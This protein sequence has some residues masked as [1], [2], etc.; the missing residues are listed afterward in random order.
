V[1]TV[2][3]GAGSGCEGRRVAGSSTVPRASEA[4]PWP[5]WGTAGRYLDGRRADGGD[6]AISLP[7]G[8]CTCELCSTLKAFL[9][10]P[11]QRTYEWRLRKDDRHHIHSRIDAAELPVTHVTR[12][13]G[14]PYTLVVT[15]TDR[16]FE[17]EREARA[18]DAASL[19]WLAKERNVSR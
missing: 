10:N 3:S 1:I 17:A 12:R 11:A 2:G 7:A 9:A 15:K 6:W 16:L 13:T 8:G 4:S 18:R 14:S 19:E 5:N